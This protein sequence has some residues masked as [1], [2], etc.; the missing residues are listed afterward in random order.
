MYLIYC[1][2]DTWCQGWEEASGYFLVSADSFGQACEKL[3]T[4]SKFQ[5]KTNFRNFDDCTIN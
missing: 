3:Q 5:D 1:D 4:C 2:Y